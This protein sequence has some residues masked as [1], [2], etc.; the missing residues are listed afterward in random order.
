MSNPLIPLGGNSLEPSRGGL[1]PSQIERSTKREMEGL[2]GRALVTRTREQVR[3]ILAHEM[4][5]ELGALSA[6]EA[7]IISACPLAEARIKHIVDTTAV[8]FG[9][10]LLRF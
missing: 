1:F 9:N 5:Q 6:E 2:A 4:V 8:A 10:A 3:G 7:A